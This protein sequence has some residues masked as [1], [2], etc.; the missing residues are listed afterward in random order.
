[1]KPEAGSPSDPSNPAD[2]P[3][4]E[5]PIRTRVAGLQE[6]GVVSLA[7]VIVVAALSLAQ[8]FFVPVFVSIIL[9]LAL[10]RSVR[11]LERIMPRW[12]ASAMVV[13]TLVGVLGA[14]AYSLSAE[15]A[16]AIA[17]LPKATRTLRQAARVFLRQKGGSLEQLQRA[18]DE[19]ER[20]AT[21][22][23][24]RP[25]TP[26]GVTAVQ[27]VEPPVDFGNVMW[28]G[29]QGVLW[30]GA[31]LT[32]VLFLVY[33]LLAYGDL[34]KRKLI[35][36]SGDT[37][38]KRKVTVQLIDE[39][40]DSVAK[41]I[42]HLTLTSVV[43]G[44]ATTICLTLLDVNYA[45]LWGL[46]AGLFN[47]I[48]YV[49]PL[50]VAAGLFLAGIVQFGDLPTA[51]LVGGVSIA[52]TSVEGFVFTP[53]V[54]GRAARVNPVAVFVGFLFWGWLWGL[55]GML[56]ALPLLLIMRV[57]AD[58]VEDLSPLAELLSD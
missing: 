6:Y 53:I 51:A 52:I 2:A 33:F 22:S 29:S 34:F 31:Q 12:L 23:T 17:E 3:Q 4:P 15:V 13:V 5:P 48:P 8:G 27:V 26:S 49:G 1:M 14:G 32:L 20:T 56:L 39:I 38:T 10:A 45:A 50:M 30:I 9:A 58:K 55:W 36:L 41:T 44:V 46:A 16:G 57:V 37:L 43:V 40:G 7:V 19:L 24:E 21:E 54:F 11:K 28:L 25:T 47:F 35:R 42:S 18:I